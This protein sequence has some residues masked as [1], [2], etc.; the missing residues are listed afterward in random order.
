[1]RAADPNNDQCSCTKVGHEAELSYSNFSL[2]Q[3]CNPPDLSLTLRK[4]TSQQY[5]DTIPLLQ[6]V[7]LISIFKLQ[8]GASTGRFCLL[9]GLWKIFCQPPIW[10]KI[11]G[12]IFSGAYCAPAL[13][14]IGRLADT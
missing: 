4:I 3:A 7:K 8:Q 6:N 5:G 12:L 13:V 14:N 2:G 10:L 9:H 1:V 11:A